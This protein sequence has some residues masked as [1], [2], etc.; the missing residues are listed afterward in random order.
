MRLDDRD[1]CIL[2]ILQ[3]EGRISKTEL[4]TRVNLSPT[5]CWE[6]L[7]KLEETG[8]IQGYGAHISLSKLG[9]LSIIFMEVEIGSHLREDFD[10]FERELEKTPEVVECWAVGGGIDYIL[11]F[12]CKDINAYQKLVDELLTAEIGLKRYYTYVVTK[13]VKEAPTPPLAI[14]AGPSEK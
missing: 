11:K 14:Y 6:R 10:R 8:V 1:I 2:A 5:A 9:P 13:P 4:A 7:K 3:T 12:A